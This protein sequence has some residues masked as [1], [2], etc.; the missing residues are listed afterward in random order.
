MPQSTTDTTEAVEAGYEEI[1]TQARAAVRIPISVKLGPYFTCL[2]QLVLRLRRAGADGFVLFNRYYRPTIDIET[3]KVVCGERYSSPGES[4]VSLRWLSILSAVVDADFAGAT[5]IHSGDDVVRALLAGADAAQ[6]VSVLY[7]RK[8]EYL[9]Q[10]LTDLE[11]WMTDKGYEAVSDFR[12]M[13]AQGRNPD[14]DLFGRLQYI[15][16]LVGIE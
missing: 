12:G 1:V 14:T 5:G 15:R 8:P 6:V 3:L 9:G 4:S 11:E 16:G 10:I 7:R 13:L 2:P